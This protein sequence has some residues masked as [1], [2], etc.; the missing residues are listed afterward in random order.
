MSNLKNS[1]LDS[2]KRGQA[3]QGEK[4]KVIDN[5][6]AKHPRWQ[7]GRLFKVASLPR[8]TYYFEK[9]KK[10]VD[11][12]KNGELCEQIS[13][14]FHE[15]HGRYGFR[16]IQAALRNEGSIVNH[17][18][19]IRLMKKLGL[20]TVIRKEKY[21]SYK[22]EV[23]VV[24]DNVLARDFHAEKPNEKWTTDVPSSTVHLAKHI[25]LRFSIWGRAMLS[26]GIYPYRPTLN[27]QSE[28]WIKPCIHILG[29]MDSFFIVIKGG[30]INIHI[31]S[32]G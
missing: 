28:C 14:I 32:S 23:G 18:K 21:K 2:T 3:T 16:R 20:K 24:A 11:G 19:I 9:S 17:K 6:L 15:N 10:D 22:G 8:S 12:E 5:L 31:T 29:W 30:N 26:R 4:A 27:K 25:Y 7:L 13:R 1:T